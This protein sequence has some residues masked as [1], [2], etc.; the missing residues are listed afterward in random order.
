MIIGINIQH[1]SSNGN[2]DLSLKKTGN[3]PVSEILYHKTLINLFENYTNVRIIIV[4]TKIDGNNQYNFITLIQHIRLSY[5]IP[6]FVYKNGDVQSEKE[7]ELLNMLNENEIDIYTDNTIGLDCLHL[8]SEE[9]KDKISSKII[10]PRPKSSGHDM[11]NKW[12]PYK[13]LKAMNF[14]D[15]EVDYKI[16]ENS[17]SED[18]YFKKLI[19]TSSNSSYNIN[20]KLEKSIKNKLKLIKAMDKKVCLID[21]ESDKGWETVFSEIFNSSN[22]KSIYPNSDSLLSPKEKFKDFMKNFNLNNINYDLVI[23]DLRLFETTDDITVDIES[24]QKLSGIQILNISKNKFPTTPVIISTASDKA[25]NYENIINSGANGFWTK[26]SPNLNY[27]ETHSFN[28]LYNL[29]KNIEK[30]LQW[31]I[32]TYDIITKINDIYK[33]FSKNI[34][35]S[36]QILIKKKTIFS[37]LHMPYSIFLKNYSNQSGY[38]FSF[39]SAWGLLLNDIVNIKAEESS[40][41]VIKKINSIKFSDSTKNNF[42]K[43]LFNNHSFKNFLRETINWNQINVSLLEYLLSEYKN[44]DL[45]NNSI[46]DYIK[47]YCQINKISFKR[48]FNNY[49]DNTNIELLNKKLSN[50]KNRINTIDRFISSAKGY[51]SI[52]KDNFKYLRLLRN[53]L[54]TTHGSNSSN[55]SYYNLS[56]IHL[57]DIKNLIDLCYLITFKKIK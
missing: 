44:F 8:L 4:P 12:G 51:P 7:D 53:N 13:L 55:N 6:I 5:N 25:W 18:L 16:I 38:E 24:L 17:L 36:N 41:M 3:L 39:E 47:E 21:D 9:E 23:L 50:H 32:N 49:E 46:L 1:S 11:T 15:K 35:K 33:N 26:E 57:N 29:L 40:A 56:S 52:I 27:S 19:N 45:T 10:P 2:I 14:F 34:T 22:F 28:N 42:Y 30:C 43:R 48:Y 31:R 20:D 54:P 37:Q